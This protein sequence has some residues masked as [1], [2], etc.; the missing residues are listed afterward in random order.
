M[1]VV[2]KIKSKNSSSTREKL[3]TLNRNVSKSKSWYSQNFVLKIP[4][5][6]I[7]CLI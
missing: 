2:K 5:F 3:E 4:H 1:D 6:N 7:S